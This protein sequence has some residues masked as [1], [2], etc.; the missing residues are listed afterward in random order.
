V[1]SGKIVRVTIDLKLS[2]GMEVDELAALVRDYQVRGMRAG[3]LPGRSIQRMESEAALSTHGELSAQ[4]RRVQCSIRTTEE[5]GH[6]LGAWRSDWINISLS[7]EDAA[8]LLSRQRLAQAAVSGAQPIVALD[9]LAGF[10][11]RL[12]AQVYEVPRSWPI[13]AGCDSVYVHGDYDDEGSL[14]STAPR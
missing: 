8:R 13:P 4:V 10:Y 7:A 9:R 6:A 5:R 14:R 2:P 1:G 12:T 11:E 3:L